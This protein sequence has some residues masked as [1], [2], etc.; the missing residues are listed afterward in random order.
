M[1]A[2]KAA[3]PDL[4]RMSRSPVESGVPR[5]KRSDLFQYPQNEDYLLRLS[6]IA[7]LHS[8]AQRS[9]EYERSPTS[10]DVRQSI[11][12]TKGRDKEPTLSDDENQKN[13]VAR[14]QFNPRNPV[15]KTA[16][17]SQELKKFE[18]YSNWHQFNNASLELM[19]VANSG[20]GGVLSYDQT[21]GVSTA[22]IPEGSLPQNQFAVQKEALP[23]DAKDD[24]EQAHSG[25]VHGASPQ[26][27]GP[28]SH[29]KDAVGQKRRADFILAGDH[30]DLGNNSDLKIKQS[31]AIKVMHQTSPS[32]ML[33]TLKQENALASRAVGAQ[34]RQNRIGSRNQGPITG[35]EASRK[36]TRSRVEHMVATIQT[37]A[38]LR[39]PD[40]TSGRSSRD[41]KE[42]ESDRLSRTH[43]TFG[44]KTQVKQATLDG[45]F[46]NKTETKTKS[47]DSPKHRG[48]QERT[49]FVN[50]QEGELGEDRRL[51][52]PRQSRN[53]V[54][55]KGVVPSKN[56]DQ[57]SSRPTSPDL[58]MKDN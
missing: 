38:P 20:P 23:G 22:L 34:N 7:G 28:E 46:G 32:D 33:N 16:D 43:N 25:Q 54:I 36:R 27:V 12:Q 52:D 49:N 30:R 21:A 45:S 42:E 6:G 51:R 37:G 58:G 4:S 18:G 15:L 3:G 8:T 35:F 2:S 39:F 29:G 24:L 50:V 1:M 53:I 47:L 31:A 13:R 14:Q 48:P 57:G 40:A 5:N 11:S 17:C 56:A 19:R 41:E 10:I 26:Q 9:E 55:I 44:S